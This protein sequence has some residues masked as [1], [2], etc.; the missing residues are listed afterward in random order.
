MELVA[1]KTPHRPPSRLGWVI[2][3]EPDLYPVM[4]VGT[5]RV[6]IALR[7]AGLHHVVELLV[8]SIA[9]NLLGLFR[10]GN[11]D[12]DD[13]HDRNDADKDPV[14]FYDFHNKPPEFDEPGSTRCS[15]S[16][17][18][19]KYEIDQPCPDRQGTEGEGKGRAQCQLVSRVG[20]EGE[21]NQ[22]HDGNSGKEE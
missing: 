9:R 15:V 1:E 17:S 14:P 19:D 3:R 11:G 5:E 6:D 12:E 13:H 2:N 21:A 7:L 10:P 22:K 16:F 4:A 18:L 20:R 8:G